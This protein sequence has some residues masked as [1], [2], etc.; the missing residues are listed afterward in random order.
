MY[1]HKQQLSSRRSSS[2][3]SSREPLR[4]TM[5]CRSLTRLITPHVV[6][7]LLGI[8]EL[9]QAM[10]QMLLKKSAKIRSAA[11]PGQ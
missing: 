10:W 8:W 11:H 2:S 5:A 6:S 4:S 3:S 9:S 1:G 7:C